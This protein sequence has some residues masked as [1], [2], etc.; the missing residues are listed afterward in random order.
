MHPRPAPGYPAQ[1]DH[2][3]KATLWKLMDVYKAAGIELTESYAMWPGAAVSGIYIAHP[4]S[5]YFGVGKVERDQTADDAA[6]RAGRSR[7]PSA[8]WC[9]RS[10][11]ITRS[12][13][14]G[15]GLI[16]GA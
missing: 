15:G 16:S 3:E 2:T 8:G 11:T 1:P 14:R 7:R 6:A 4:D 12:S 13:A 5:H 10:I 9:R